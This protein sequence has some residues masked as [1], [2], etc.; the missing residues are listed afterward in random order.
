M[1]LA[2]FKKRYQELEEQVKV[3]DFTKSNNADLVELQ[4]DLLS[5]VQTLM[6]D[7]QLSLDE[8]RGLAEQTRRVSDL[9]TTK[10]KAERKQKKDK[11]AKDEE[12]KKK[13]K[14]KK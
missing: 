8:L 5:D 2:D 1:S 7:K 14:P 13:D 9:L 12:E 10:V 11:E 3:H 6:N 4:L